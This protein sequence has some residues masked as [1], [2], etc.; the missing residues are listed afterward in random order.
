M[1]QRSVYRRFVGGLGAS[2]IV[3]AA[4]VA[5]GA[6]LLSEPAEELA[7]EPIPFDLVVPDVPPPAVVPDN[8]PTENTAAAVELP[9]APKPAPAKRA[10]SQPAAEDLAE[11]A[12]KQQLEKPAKSVVEAPEAS[13]TSLVAV[14][15]PPDAGLAEEPPAAEAGTPDQQ[16]A[17][18]AGTTDQQAAAGAGT[19]DQQ[20]AAGAEAP[21]ADVTATPPGMAEP[22]SAGEQQPAAEVDKALQGVQATAGLDPV[23]VDLRAFVPA[24]SRLMLVIRVDRVR[25]TP[26]A[27]AMDAILSPMPDYKTIIASNNELKLADA[28][29]SLVIATPDPGDVTGT[30]LAA[31]TTR[32]VASIRDNLSSKPPVA[33]PKPPAANAKP[34]ASPKPRVEWKET[35][36]VAVGTRTER[37]LAEMKDSRV[38]VIPY[39]G[40][41]VLTRPE[42]VPHLIP[43]DGAAKNAKAPDWLSRLAAIEAQTGEGENA[44]FLVLSAADMDADYLQVPGSDVELPVPQRLTVTMSPHPD[45]VVFSGAAVFGD[46]ATA[47]TFYEKAQDGQK[48]ALR[49]FATKFILDR[50][51]CRGAIERLQFRHSNE[52][53]T[54]STTLGAK[55]AA[56]LF[57][58]AALWST[59]YFRTARVKPKQDKPQDTKEK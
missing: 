1:A 36:G 7:A 5:V 3:H 55:D 13:S 51:H 57:K 50:L 44:P 29:E 9:A 23:L 27:P 4:L 12:Q 24:G 14:T 22:P 37:W 18:G 48:G 41:I 25:N 49:D 56:G 52:F 39:G 31:R 21:P 17:A 59:E 38:F 53:V 45:G 6:W 10:W 16:A 58:A 19:T 15:L 33:T 42:H 47:K 11:L 40:W 34:P 20:A 2:L 43:G 26:W 35:S 28:F 54:F 32:D 46:A 8:L 30:F